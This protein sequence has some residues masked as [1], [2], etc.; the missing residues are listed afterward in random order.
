MLWTKANLS[1]HRRCSLIFIIGK[2]FREQYEHL[3]R[4]ES[5]LISCWCGISLKWIELSF[6]YSI[7]KTL[8]FKSQLVYPLRVQFIMEKGFFSWRMRFSYLIT[9]SSNSCFVFPE[10]AVRKHSLITRRILFSM[11]K[12]FTVHLVLKL[13]RWKKF[14][15][16]LI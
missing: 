10:Y 16:L 2:R 4:R 9:L 3:Q 15:T 6:F 5:F 12:Y 14:R 13:K 1:L 7:N 11:N 8:L